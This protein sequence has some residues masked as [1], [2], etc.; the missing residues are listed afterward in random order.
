MLRITTS[1]IYV[2]SDVLADRR[3]CSSQLIWDYLV[4]ACIFVQGNLVPK[5]SKSLFI[6]PHEDIV[7]SKLRSIKIY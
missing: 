2:G 5:E 4:C 3:I 6:F 7:N 1:R